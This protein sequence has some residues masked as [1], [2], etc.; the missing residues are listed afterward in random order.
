M[1]KWAATHGTVDRRTP[2]RRLGGRKKEGEKNGGERRERRER[3][4]GVVVGVG[5]E[6]SG[7]SHQGRLAGWKGKGGGG[8]GKLPF[9]LWRGSK[10]GSCES[11][12][13]IRSLISSTTC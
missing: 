9:C 13:H 11:I 10:R 2:G 6:G 4:R 7:L 3:E 1:G 8:R 5:R 12:Y